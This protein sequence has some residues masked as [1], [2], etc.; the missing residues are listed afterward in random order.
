VVVRDQRE[1]KELV[2][3]LF[4]RTFRV[5]DSV[6]WIVFGMAVLGLVVSAL[7]LLWERRRE[8]K[9]LVVLGAS[10]AQLV[11]W[12]VLEGVLVSLGPLILGVVMGTVMGWALTALINPISFG[13]TL[14]FSLSYAPLLVSVAFAVCVT[15][16]L[17]LTVALAVGGIVRRTA[18]ADE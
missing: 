11:G 5:T 17:A 2:M 7:Q 18:L 4:D 13:W 12:S 3:V 15:G 14:E 8:V 1:L 10:S 6:R 16:L 9:T